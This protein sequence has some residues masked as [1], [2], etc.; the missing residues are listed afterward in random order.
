MSDASRPRLPQIL[1]HFLADAFRLHPDPLF[2]KDRAYRTVYVNEAFSRFVGIPAEKMIGRDDFEMLPRESAIACRAN[3]ELSLPREGAFQSGVAHESDEIFPGANGPRTLRVQRYV[4]ADEKG[5]PFLIGSIRDV[6]E[7]IR[8]A[9]G[10][11]SARADLR[12]SET[13]R[14]ETERRLS[15]VF[16]LIDEVV[17]SLEWDTWNPLFISPSAGRV[18]GRPV[19]ALLSREEWGRIFDPETSS[20]FIG[21]MVSVADRGTDAFNGFFAFHHPDRGV[22]EGFIRGRIVRDAEGRPNRVEGMTTDVT[23]SRKAVREL[24]EHRQRLIALSKWNTLG[25]LASGIGHEI[26]TPLSG[27]LSKVARAERILSTGATDRETGARLLRESMAIIDRVSQIV[28]GLKQLSRQQQQAEELERFDPAV[29]VE[30]ALS[31]SRARFS[32]HGYRIEVVKPDGP[33]LCLGRPTAVFQALVNLLNNAF[34]AL[35]ARDAS[36]SGAP[37]EAIRVEILRDGDG[38]SLR[39]IDTGV[40]IDESFRPR[41]FEAF[42]TTKPEGKGTGLGLNISR[43]LLRANGADLRLVSSVPGRTEFAIA[44]PSA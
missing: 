23:E 20:R 21:M 3:D 25:E 30:Q 14:Q 6:T 22:R 5:E 2:V 28:D 29:A 15:E 38:I 1:S 36:R 11:R 24:E 4:L 10:L 16:E 39:V 43:R 42:Q 13:Q 12:A 7:V 32:N 35:E 8:D 44:L 37:R 41:L 26:N 27:I 40:G 17:W 33:L 9:E 34:D 31:L 18:F 19:E